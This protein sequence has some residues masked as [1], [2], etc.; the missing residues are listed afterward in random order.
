MTDELLWSQC[1]L[2]VLNTNGCGVCKKIEWDIAKIPKRRFRDFLKRIKGLFSRKKIQ[3]NTEE[4]EPWCSLH[5]KFVKPTD[6]CKDYDPKKQIKFLGTK[7][8]VTI[9]LDKRLAY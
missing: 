2:E 7:S 8:D 3:I 6:I 9:A 1:N 5:K 4:P